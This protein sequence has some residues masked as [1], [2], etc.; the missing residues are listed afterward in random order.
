VYRSSA[1]RIRNHCTGLDGW[2]FARR[3]LLPLKW[4]EPGEDRFGSPATEWHC[5]PDVR[6][7]SKSD[8]IAALRQASLGPD[9]AIGA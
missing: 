6:F 5:P 8:R 2:V 4:R 9:L 1:D 3:I 7:Y